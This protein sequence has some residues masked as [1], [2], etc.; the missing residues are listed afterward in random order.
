MNSKPRSRT[1]QAP[2]APSMPMPA[3]VAEWAKVR[4]DSLAPWPLPVDLSG[5]H[6]WRVSTPQWLIDVRV[7][8][9]D[10]DLRREVI[11]YRTA[12]HRLDP[13]HGPRLIAYEPRLRTLL[14]THPRGRPVDDA[15][16]LHV[17]PRI[18]QDAGR[19]LAVARAVCCASTRPM[20]PTHSCSPFRTTGGWT[21]AITPTTTDSFGPLT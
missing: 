13:T 1:R 20:S 7:V 19:L 3:Q 12:I 4:I 18:H 14:I 9:T 2:P 10:L 21:W 17:L 15:A 11:A 5:A 8:R 6:S 16:S